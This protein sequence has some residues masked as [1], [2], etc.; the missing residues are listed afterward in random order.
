LVRG[1]TSLPR[2]QAGWDLLIFLIGGVMKKI[3]SFLFLL[4]LTI[5]SCKDDPTAPEETTPT[6]Q[7]L[8]EKTIGPEGGTLETEKFKLKVP[9]GSFSQST[10]L[11][12][13]A[14]KKT[15]T[16]SNSVTDAFR[17]E[18]VP[19]KYNQPLEISIKYSGTLTGTNF[20]ERAFEAE[21]NHI[22]STFVDTVYNLFEAV[23]EN[24]YLKTSIPP[25]TS[26]T[27]SS[28]VSKAQ[29]TFEYWLLVG[30]SNGKTETSEHFTLKTVDFAKDQYSQ[31]LQSLLQLF[32]NSY[33]RL[34][35]LD[36]D[37]NLTTWPKII[38]V[39]KDLSLTSNEITPDVNSKDIMIKSNVNLDYLLGVQPFCDH[40]LC[41]IILKAYKIQNEYD[42]LTSGI[43]WWTIFN[44]DN[45]LY[46][47]DINE[48][49]EKYIKST[50]NGEKSAIS[51]S[52]IIE[53][54]VKNYGEAILK[55]IMSDV[56]WGQNP[57]LAIISQTDQPEVWLSDLF[58]SFVSGQVWLN[59]LKYHDPNASLIDI[60]NYNLSAQ[61]GIDD[62]TTQINYT[63][64]YKD[65]SAK[66]YKIALLPS[67][68]QGSTL[69]LS[70]EGG[71]TKISVYK[72]KND[73]VEFIT[74]SEN[75][76]TIDGV[77]NLQANGYNLFVMVSN[78]MPNYPNATTSNITFKIKHN[79]ELV[80]PKVVDC[81]I[82]L[83]DLEVNI[84]TYYT[85]GYVD[86]TR[87]LT[88][89]F[90]PQQQPTP[91][92]INNVFYQAY[93]YTDQT[94]NNIWGNF[95]VQFNNS[96]DSVIAFSAEYNIDKTPVNPLYG[97]VKQSISGHDI[98]VNPQDKNLFNVIGLETCEKI[99]NNVYYSQTAPS[100]WEVISI[101]E[102]KANTRV[103]IRITKE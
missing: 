7:V 8:A 81:E 47:E 87:M 41:S 80:P 73:V 98:P 100:H 57:M 53:H 58:E 61:F 15:S 32:E 10:Q 91:T 30:L 99:Y 82:H 90:Y 38:T 20:I 37:F 56:A 84:R 45:W 43:A 48:I 96:L 46:L 78:H 5:V 34:N 44:Y 103:E 66:L 24:G 65:L 3:I 22:D 97:I 85:T 50:L 86:G 1:G 51:L 17:L 25:V 31:K 52:V 69:K 76:I 101:K 75:E 70:A 49:K 35:A 29:N 28:I 18:G 63:E 4:L 21:L 71:D 95:S 42:Y 62:T 94:G 6:E 40:T 67:L 88:L 23:E 36:F 9:A 54:L 83:Y 92:F 27:N 14:D 33:T 55:N 2:R 74:R 12:L 11:K 93:T 60:W 16:N 59:R 13:F 79:T 72:Y 19:E 102:C 68:K 89:H 64:S 77:K 26:V 39:K